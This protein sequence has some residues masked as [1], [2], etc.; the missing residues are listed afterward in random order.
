MEEATAGPRHSA[1]PLA[2]RFVAGFA[3]AVEQSRPFFV[4]VYFAGPRARCR[5]DS[6]GIQTSSPSLTLPLLTRWNNSRDGENDIQH[7]ES[8]TDGTDGVQ[9]GPCTREVHG[10]AR[11][12]VPVRCAL[13]K[14]TWPLGLRG[15]APCVGVRC[16][17]C[18]REV[19]CGARGPVCVAHSARAAQRVCVE[20]R[21]G[22]SVRGGWLT[23]FAL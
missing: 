18:T 13:G 8:D 19:H 23:G 10:G 11:G 6:R 22:L 16:A 5:Y 15:L 21:V 20:G 9:C 17:P 4:R 1:G 2:T 14:C 7:R 3:A 12:P